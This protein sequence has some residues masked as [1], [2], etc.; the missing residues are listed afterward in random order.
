MKDN[1]FAVAS[2]TN[3]IA[4]NARE[5]VRIF[6][7]KNSKNSP[8]ELWIKARGL[9]LL[10]QYFV[11][12]FTLLLFVGCNP[13]AIKTKGFDNSIQFYG[14]VASEEPYA[15]LAAQDVL[16]AGGTAADAAL[17]AY[18]T[19]AVTYPYAASLGGGGICIYYDSQ[20]NKAE[21][22]SFLVRKPRDG[23]SVGIPG[24]LRGMAALHSRYGRLR[25]QRIIA[26]A[27][28][29]ALLGVRAS[30]ALVRRVIRSKDRL[31]SSFGKRTP[32]LN[33]NK[34][35]VAESEIII[36]IELAK[37]LSEIRTKGVGEFYNGQLALQFVEQAKSVDGRITLD[38]LRDYTPIWR[39]TIQNP[40]GYEVLHTVPSTRGGNLARKLARY[41]FSELVNEP[42]AGRDVLSEVMQKQDVGDAALVVGDKEGSAV[43]CSFT[44]NDA[45]GTGYMLPDNGFWVA[46][47]K[48]PDEVISSPMLIVNHHTSQAFFGIAASQGVAGVAT[49]AQV[50]IST[51]KGKRKLEKSLSVERKYKF[52][53]PLLDEADDT[54]ETALGVVQTFSCP[55]GLRDG[56]SSCQFISD[57]RGYG[58]AL[59]ER[60]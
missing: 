23:G 53:D 35:V 47:P 9:N 31:Y 46:P 56:F 6:L 4:Q 16:M 26:P 21:S 36:Q 55:K 38:D 22:L 10:R 11:Y 44:M 51:V 18:F 52:T 12:S 8:Q 42:A 60:F 27:E 59:V 34:E 40:I 19:M 58:L 43:A 32:L 7:F 15:A 54:N 33:L 24:N 13:N 41:S 25:L 1:D 2:N 50:L 28:K 30:R 57:P 49:A 14:G 20:S 45:F 3:P 37:V 39:K 5:Q 17:S 48:H 29:L